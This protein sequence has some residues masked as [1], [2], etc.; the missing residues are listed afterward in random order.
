MRTNVD[1][2]PSLSGRSHGI[3]LV[4]NPRIWW[5]CAETKEAK[6]DWV[7]LFSGYIDFYKIFSEM[8][9]LE[10]GSSK[11][12][13]IKLNITCTHEILKA[14]YE[15]LESTRVF[16]V[17]AQDKHFLE[18]TAAARIVTVTEKAVKLA[19]FF[20]VKWNNSI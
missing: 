13:F 17:M 4:T 1:G 6:D 19:R 14:L 3:C 8:S 11:T 7:E 15:V 20:F 5:V 18:M 16:Y 12:F 2:E 9:T 10:P